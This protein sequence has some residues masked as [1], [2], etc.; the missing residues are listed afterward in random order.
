VF[1]DDL[2]RKK[3]QLPELVPG[4]TRVLSVEYAFLGLF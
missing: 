3:P 1:L 2:D 4:G